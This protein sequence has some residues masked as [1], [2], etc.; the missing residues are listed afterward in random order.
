MSMQEKMVRIV[1][2]GAASISEG[3]MEPRD[4]VDELMGALAEPTP[5]FIDA[6][7]GYFMTPRDRLPGVW[8][9]MIRAAKDGK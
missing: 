9:A 5:E 7:A 2:A 8:A 6:I 3:V 4:V 1:A